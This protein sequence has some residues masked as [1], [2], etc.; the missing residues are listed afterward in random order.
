MDVNIKGF[1]VY[2]YAFLPSS[3]AKSATVGS[4][5]IS[6][7]VGRLSGRSPLLSGSNRIR[8]GFPIQVS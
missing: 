5:L 8:I 6:S 1:T 2:T 3:S 7:Q 4:S